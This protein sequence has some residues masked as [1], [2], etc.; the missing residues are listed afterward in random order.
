[1]TRPIVAVGLL[2]ALVISATACLAAGQEESAVAK[3][4]AVGTLWAFPPGLEFIV[5][6]G[7]GY[8]SVEIGLMPALW[9]SGDDVD[10][11]TVARVGLLLYP[12][13]GARGVA[14]YTALT[15]ATAEV[16]LWYVWRGPSG[17]ASFRLGAGW[18]QHLDASAGG[19][20]GFGAAIGFA[21]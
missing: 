8:G 9:S 18:V 7:G 17:R 20:P 13:G 2:L 15:V 16:G 19:D 21:F 10:T 6:P 3:T 5:A 14:A 4:E 12:G 11:D 1:M